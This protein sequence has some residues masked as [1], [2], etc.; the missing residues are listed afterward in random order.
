MASGS[1]NIE[2]LSMYRTLPLQYDV[3]PYSTNTIFAVGPSTFLEPYTFYDLFSTNNYMDPSTMSTYFI[4]TLNAGLTSTTAYI[5]KQVVSTLSYSSNFQSTSA[6]TTSWPIVI[7]TP[8]IDL[9][10]LSTLFFPK[11]YDIFVEGS[12]NIK[13]GDTNEPYVYISTVGVFGN[14]VAGVNEG[15]TYITRASTDTYTTIYTKLAYPA[16]PQQI[17]NNRP[18]NSSTFYYQLYILSSGTIGSPTDPS[19]DLYIPA[20]NNLYFSFI[21][22]QSTFT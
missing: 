5:G 13:I 1:Y 16:T 20:S 18:N 6:G 15:S 21:P 12:Y 4:S 7:S 9:G 2:T 10:G 11:L 14:Y 8:T 22:S 3:I 17:L 19:F